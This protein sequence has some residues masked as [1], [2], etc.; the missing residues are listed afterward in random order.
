M[1]QQRKVD[2]IFKRKSSASLGQSE[3]KDILNESSIPQVLIMLNVTLRANL[4]KK[5][6]IQEYPREQCD[7]IRRAYLSINLS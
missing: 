2:S 5:K 6:Q 3:K 1:R 7:T 4:G